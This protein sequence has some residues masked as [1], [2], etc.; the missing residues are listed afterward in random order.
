[1]T[2]YDQFAI[3]AFEA[4]ALDYLVKPVSDAR[5][6]ATAK[7]LGRQLGVFGGAP[8]ER[9]IVVATGRGSVV[10]SL[11]EIDWI[12][13]ADN[14]SRIWVGTRSYLLREPLRALEERV[15]PHGFVRAHRR[16]IVPLSNV[17]Q[18][19]WRDGG[20]LVAQLTNGVEIHV[21]RRRRA[22]FAAAVRSQAR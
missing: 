18:L 14:Y 19:K 11:H 2:A 7:R 6:A 13:A 1:L 4:Q 22:A 9:V 21:S 10:L 15:R 12:E 20:E 8:R 5:F 17:K 3:R 16:A